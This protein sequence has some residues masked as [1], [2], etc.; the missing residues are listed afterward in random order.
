M[1]L[2]WVQV[3][4]L[5]HE[6][7]TWDALEH[8]PVVEGPIEHRGDRQHVTKQPA[9]SSTGRLEVSSVEARPWRCMM[10][11][12]RSSAAVIGGLRMPR[13]AMI[14]NGTGGKVGKIVFARAVEHGIGEVFEQG[15]G[16]AAGDLAA[17]LD[18]GV[19]GGLRGVV[20]AGAGWADKQP[21]LVGGNEAASGKLEDQVAAHLL[22]EVQRLQCTTC[23]GNALKSSRWA[24]GPG[25]RPRPVCLPMCHSQPR[26][27]NPRG[28]PQSSRPDG[29]NRRGQ[30]DEKSTTYP[31]TALHS[32][33]AAV[34]RHNLMRD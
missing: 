12:K 13:S 9:P 17:L 34:L 24:A 23:S 27:L 5:L 19:A 18:G 6:P 14:R 31:L 28:L 21:A 30:M 8:V 16:F 25:P 22:V 4:V 32:N 3:G 15:V 1:F 2:L 26:R 20:L 33:E 11:S 10:I 29:A 7:A